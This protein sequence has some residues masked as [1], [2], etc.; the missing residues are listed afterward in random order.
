MS[1]FE[2]TKGYADLGTKMTE[3]T[4]RAKQGR[5]TEQSFQAQ[6]TQDIQL[7]VRQGRDVTDHTTTH[8]DTAD[9][10]Q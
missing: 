5:Q 9:Y 6:E 1:E 7:K 10:G 2:R 3:D 4:E 8:Q